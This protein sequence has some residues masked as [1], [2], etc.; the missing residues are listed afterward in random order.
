MGAPSATASVGG[1][2][3]FAVAILRRQASRVRRRSPQRGGGI[4]AHALAARKDIGVRRDEPFR[5]LLPVVLTR[6]LRPGKWRSVWGRHAPAGRTRLAQLVV[7]A[8]LGHFALP[9]L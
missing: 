2:R 8:A 7:R 3:R 5:D 6:V 1:I 9:E 4:H